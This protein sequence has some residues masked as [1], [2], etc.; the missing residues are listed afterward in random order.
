[1]IS[2]VEGNDHLKPH[3]FNDEYLLPN[4]Y[5][6]VDAFTAFLEWAISFIQDMVDMVFGPIVE[7]I[8]DAVD[9]YT[10]GILSATGHAK[11]DLIVT[12]RWKHSDPSWGS[13]QISM[14]KVTLDSEWDSRIL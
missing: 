1:M 13:L 11:N 2:I 14:S 3:T 4:Q 12:V 6:I 8:E 9:S 10:H 7:A 5:A